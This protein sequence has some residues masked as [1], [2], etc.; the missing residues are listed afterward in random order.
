MHYEEPI[1]KPCIEGENLAIE[2]EYTS[3]MSEDLDT[4]Q[5]SAIFGIG[6]GRGTAATTV[7]TPDSFTMEIGL[8][9]EIKPE[10]PIHSFGKN[11]FYCIV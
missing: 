7:N 2:Q 9:K 5:Q 4:K 3:G 11:S 1:G 8:A 10:L 6:Q